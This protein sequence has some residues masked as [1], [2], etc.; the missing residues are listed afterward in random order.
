MELYAKEA[1]NTFRVMVDQARELVLCEGVVFQRHIRSGA[2]FSG[3]GNWRVRKREALRIWDHY[4]QN[5]IA[6]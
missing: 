1:L 6:V 3:G 4:K 5:S 2:V